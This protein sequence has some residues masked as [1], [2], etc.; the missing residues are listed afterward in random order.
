[1]NLLIM[2][3]N[4]TKAY[5]QNHFLFLG[6]SVLTI[7][8]MVVIVKVKKLN[9]SQIL[10]FM[11]VVAVA[12]ELIV[13]TMNVTVPVYNDNEELI[14]YLLSKR[15]LPLHMCSI[16]IFFII[17]LN[18]V[19]N[20]KF[21]N[22]LLAFMYPTCLAGALMALLIPT[23][24]DIS[25]GNLRTWEFFMF[26]AFLVGFGLCIALS[27]EVKINTKSC[28]RTS[29]ILIL[30][31]IAS[32]YINSILSI[33]GADPDL[34]TNFFFSSAPPMQGLP[35]LNMNHGWHV[36]ALSMICVGVTLMVILHIPFFIKENK[37]KKQNK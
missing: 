25:F 13:M 2:L 22:A 17:I 24:E 28:L 7:V 4:V 23:V 8:A 26:H 30:L 35:I 10:K 19:K 32:I 6:L 31:F 29:G 9:L 16:Q 15:A 27:G 36:Y 14:G 12:S 21:K 3:T 34:Q 37:E 1:M 20:E 33:P 5:G 11:A 18:I